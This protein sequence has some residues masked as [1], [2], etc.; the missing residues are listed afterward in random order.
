MGKRILISENEKIKIRN[1]YGLNE[2]LDFEQ[3]MLGIG[4]IIFLRKFFQG[5]RSDPKFKAL[6]V[7][8]EDVEQNIKHL[9]K[10][11]EKYLNGLDEYYSDIEEYDRVEIRDIYEND[12]KPLLREKKLVDMEDIVNYLSYKLDYLNKQ[13]EK[14]FFSKD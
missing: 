7:R 4:S 6:F 13:K 9:D 14:K 1:L 10:V 8:D 2:G 5:L 3:I 12:I 11:M